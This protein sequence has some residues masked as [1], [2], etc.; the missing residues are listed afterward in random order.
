MHARDEIRT[1]LTTRR[2][3]IT[4]EVAG[5]AVR[6]TRRVPGLRRGEVA[7]LAGVSVEYYAHLERGHL[8]G[9]SESVLRALSG[10]LR[11]DEAE[12]AHLR[13]LARTAGAGSRAERPTA[14]VTPRPVLQR[15]V[16]GLVELPAHVRDGRLD[17][18]VHNRMARALYAPVF[19]SAGAAGRTPNTARFTFL[20]PCARDFWP[21]WARTA[22]ETVALLRTEA[23]RAPHDEGLRDLVGELSAHSEEFRTRWAAHDVRL[24]STGAKDFHHPVVGPLHLGY[25]SLEPTADPGLTLL[26]FSAEPGSAAADGLRRLS[27]WAAAA[28][29]AAPVPTP[30]STPTPTPSGP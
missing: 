28:A 27:A 16:D 4:P 5:L 11:L 29:T 3:R 23:G 12:R 8:A 19:A 25:E 17:V 21:H 15:I 22:D 24:H 30:T 10:A 6:G 7:Q 9:V 2:A 13:D 18:L 14:P 26:V 20:D 1:F